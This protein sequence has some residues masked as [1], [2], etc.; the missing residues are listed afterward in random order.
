MKLREN[1]NGNTIEMKT[2]NINSIQK[3][4]TPSHL[5]NIRRPRVTECIEKNFFNYAK[6]AAKRRTPAAYWY[7]AFHK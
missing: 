6:I 1:D 4:K 7:T 2:Q 5:F 3:K